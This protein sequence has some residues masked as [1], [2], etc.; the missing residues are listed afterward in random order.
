T[1]HEL[2]ATRSFGGQM[3]HGR[4]LRLAML[5][6][7]YR[8][9]IDWTVARL[10]EARTKLAAWVATTIGAGPNPG[11]GGSS[12]PPGGL[13]DDLNTPE[14]LTLLRSLQKA[15]DPTSRRQLGASLRFL[16]LWDAETSVEIH[17]YGYE[18]HRAED[19]AKVQMLFE[20]RNAARAA[21]N[22]AE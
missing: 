18:V 6:T 22:W 2:L 9:P 15:K 4:V 17:G 13:E 7:H 5:G 16:G 19:R 20:A 3:W 12:D 8:Q 21:K 1:I 11:E 10:F 14:V